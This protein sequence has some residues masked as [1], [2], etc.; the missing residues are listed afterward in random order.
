MK[1]YHDVEITTMVL[2]INSQK[3]EVLL[4]NKTKG[5]WCG[6]TPPG[7]HVEPEESI[8]ACAI[9]EVKEETGL[10]VWNLK[11]KGLA[12]WIDLSDYSRYMV[13]SYTTED[14]RGELMSA[15]DEGRV[16][17]IPI[18]EFDR[19]SFAPGCRERFD[20]LFFKEGIIEL[21]GKC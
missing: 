18:S 13:F 20:Q 12:H 16:S 19:I 21:F 7:G 17:W 9:R 11:Y 4:I 15:S 1:T 10:D 2:V 8:E 6:Y 5:D 3:K 14:Y